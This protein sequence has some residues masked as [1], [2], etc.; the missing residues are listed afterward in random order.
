M[1]KTLFILV[2][3]SILIAACNLPASPAPVI[4]NTSL[5]PEPAQSLSPPTSTLEVQPT[6]DLPTFTPS[7]S[8]P[9]QPNPIHFAP[10]G[11]YLDITDMIPTA[12]SKEY[13]INAMQGQIMSISV[14]P[15]V[16]DG[17]WGY[18]SLKI[19]GADGSS[20]CPQAPD[21][22]CLY[23]RGKLPSSQEYFV[24]LTPNGNA[25]QFV[26]RVAINPPG[27]DLQ[28]FQYSNP[29]SG[30]SLTYPDTFAPAIP[31][32]GNYKINPEFTLHLIDTK[33]Y[34]KTNLGEVYLF[35]SSSS[36]SQIVADCT[37]PNENGGGGEQVVG[38]E[39]ING[40][41]FVHSTSEGA[42]AGNYY[43]QEV[44]RMVQKNVCY[45]VIYYIHYTNI[46]NYTPGTVTEYDSVALMKKFSSIFATL[47]IK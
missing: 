11:T 45:E 6:T 39:V 9:G 24:T 14:L 1:K 17:D 21:T 30:I 29:A 3:L 23:W 22:E 7:V 19:E 34:E 2:F 15:Q 12:A 13:S 5:P 20:L 38:N 27:K 28:Y 32:Y 36:D 26:M 31:V 10:N 43:Q 18:L 4:E 35:L 37:A 16:P 8:L 33:T 47:T 42:G 46:G 41:T 40:Y 25:P 44:Y